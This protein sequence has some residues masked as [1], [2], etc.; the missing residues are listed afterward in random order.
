MCTIFVSAY[1][2]FEL[3][4]DLIL[5]AAKVIAKFNTHKLRYVCLQIGLEI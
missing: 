1:C 2:H 4:A 3:L 5:Q